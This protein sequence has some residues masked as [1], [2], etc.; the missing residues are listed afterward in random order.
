VG[1]PSRIN[2]TPVVLIL[3]LFALFGGLEARAQSASVVP[4]PTMLGPTPKDE[5][6]RGLALAVEILTRVDTSE[7]ARIRPEATTPSTPG[8]SVAR[9]IW[10]PIRLPFSVD[11]RRP[12]ATWSDFNLPIAPPA[13][14]PPVTDLLMYFPRR[15]S[16]KGEDDL[17]DKRYYYQEA[18]PD[19]EDLRITRRWRI[20]FLSKAYYAEQSSSVLPSAVTFT[21]E[22]HRL[23]SVNGSAVSERQITRRWTSDELMKQDLRLEYEPDDFPSGPGATAA[24][25]TRTGAGSL[26]LLI[27][28]SLTILFGASPVYFAWDRMV[29]PQQT[30]RFRLEGIIWACGLLILIGLWFAVESGAPESGRRGFGYLVVFLG[31]AGLTTILL[32]AKQRSPA[33]PPPTP[34]RIT[35]LFVASNTKDLGQVDL[36]REHRDLQAEFDRGTQAG[37]FQLESLLAPRKRDLTRSLIRLRPRV[38]HFCGH[39][40]EE[41]RI[42]IRDNDEDALPI[43]QRS[44]AGIIGTLKDDIRLV[45]LNACYTEKQAQALT[46]DIDCAIGMNRE[47]VDKVAIEFAA[48]FYMA[49][50]NGS[51]IKE[52][53]DIAAKSVIG[54]ESRGT[55]HFVTPGSLPDRDALDNAPRILWRSGIKEPEHYRIDVVEN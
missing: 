8:G 31:C 33:M 52:A 17:N 11:Y 2:V 50:A 49:V 53:F 51:F 7:I 5:L 27:M 14:I 41:G 30:W 34:R 13:W 48:S 10:I 1:R 24:K 19:K 43:D 15:L 26:L 3:W 9:P 45:V 38:V 28:I 6:P 46:V 40:D 4:S 44:L 12:D 35:V 39:G 36:L 16:G 55:R 29:I 47:V 54:L 37:R 18:I 21:F 20:V 22:G 23:A 42:I 25:T 32:E